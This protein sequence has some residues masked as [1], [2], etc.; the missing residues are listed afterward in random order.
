MYVVLK[1]MKTIN[2]SLC[3]LCGQ[4]NRCALAE[5]TEEIADCWCVHVK[6]P[7]ERLMQISPSRLGRACICRTC[8]E[9]SV[10]ASHPARPDVR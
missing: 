4:P 3:P 7:L 1:P 9:A 8:A 6:I 2:Q 10:A 5:D